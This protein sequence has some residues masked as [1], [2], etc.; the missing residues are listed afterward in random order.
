[1]FRFLKDLGTEYGSNAV[2][3]ILIPFC[4]VIVYLCVSLSLCLI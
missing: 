4:F 1:M 2:A 3:L